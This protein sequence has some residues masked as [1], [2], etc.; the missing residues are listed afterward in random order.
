MKQIPIHVAII[1]D[2]NRR[3]ATE[4]GLPRVAGH[5]EGISAVRRT[6]RAAIDSGVRYLTLY[7]FSTENWKRP[8][9]EV[10]FLFT[11][12][13]DS[14]TEEMK[15]LHAE[16]IR[17]RFIGRIKQLPEKLQQ[18]ITSTEKL[19]EKNT[20]LNLT[21]A[22][23]YGGRQEILD[24]IE[25]I[26]HQ[27][28]KIDRLNEEKFR[29]FLYYPELPD[30]D[31]VIRTAG[32]QRLSNFLIWQSIYAEFYFIH[33]LWPDFSEKDFKMALEEFSKRKRRFGGL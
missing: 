4:K 3:W 10:K 27:K 18:I 31:M 25:K 29:D 11:L 26:I 24:A 2:G 20:R 17:V 32:E 6:V 30:V 5:K 19:T 13:E 33:T 15:S 28:F 22:L 21:F 12:M 7:S 9:D 16:N 23:N 1:M 14:L 8:P